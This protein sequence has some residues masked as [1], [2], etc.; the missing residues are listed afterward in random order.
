MPATVRISVWTPIL[1]GGTQTFLRDVDPIGSA[2]QSTNYTA[3]RARV[4][5]SLDGAFMLY[6]SLSELHNYFLTW[7]GN[8]I[9]EISGQRTWTGLVW[10]MTLHYAGIARRLS[11]ENTY[12][13]IKAKFQEL[14]SNTSFEDAGSPTYADWSETVGGT[15]SI[16]DITSDV[17][18]GGHAAKI[19]YVD[20]GTTFLY[21]DVT[22]VAGEQYRLRFQTHGDG[23]V[24]GR[25]RVRD[26]TAGSDIIALAATSISGAEYRTIV[27]EF[28]APTGCSSI[29]VYLYAPSSAGA[30]YYD[31][32]S[33]QRLVNGSP[34]YSYTTFALNDRSIARYGRREL[35]VDAGNMP[36]AGAEDFRDTQ[37]AALAWPQISAPE[38]AEEGAVEPDAARLEIEMVGYWSTAFWRYLTVFT[39]G[40]GA[41]KGDVITDILTTDCDHLSAGIIRANSSLVRLGAESE[42]RLAGDV[43][44]EIVESGDGADV[45]RLQ[46]DGQRRV[47]YE[48]IDAG[49]V[50]L[51]RR[52]GRY[53]QLAGGQA[54]VNPFVVPAGVV[55]RDADWPGGE[56]HYAG[57][58]TNAADSI[59]EEIEVTG[60]GGLRI[61]ARES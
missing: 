34:D 33:M 50:G 30:A 6:G 24:D 47:V 17:A 8:H 26:M 42:G 10:A 20:D 14:L 51:Y 49:T 13:A 41:A 39:D 56:Q 12:N 45:Y 54:A 32:V 16:S 21:Q 25:Y 52:D 5:G 57:F 15:D 53:Y 36:A 59:I 58:L 18:S 4:G 46:V 55:L 38:L 1:G 19:V 37:L 61:R 31:D 22:V 35:I 44:A 11:L 60:A 48:A 23:S 28:V 29:R 2:E 40:A 3:T 43:L 9:E 7:L 27:Q